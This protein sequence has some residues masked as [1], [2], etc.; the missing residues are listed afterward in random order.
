MTARFAQCK[1]LHSPEDFVITIHW[2]LNLIRGRPVFAGIV[3]GTW[4]C[5]QF[6]EYVKL[7]AS[8]IAASHAHPNV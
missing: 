8:G 1:V 6:L 2:G 4:K 7:N 3:H 5:V